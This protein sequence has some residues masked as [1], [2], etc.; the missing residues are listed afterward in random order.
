MELRMSA[1]NG[2][3]KPPD[4]APAE[5]GAET[6]TSVL[7]DAVRQLREVL[8]GDSR[9][10][11]NLSTAGGQ[12][13]LI[14]RRLA[15]ASEK[16]PSV[17]RE[18]GLSA[19]QVWQAVAENGGRDPRERE[20]VIVFTDLV[21]F[22]D[23]AMRVGDESALRLLRDVSDAIEPPVVA[24]RG[25]IVKR[26]GDGMM[27]VFADPRHAVDAVFEAN[28]R[29][30]MVECGGYRPQIR[31]GLHVGY[32]QRIGGDYLGIDVN[33]AA[34][35]AESAKGGEVLISEEGVSLLGDE[36]L[37][38][39]KKRFFKAKGVPSEVTVY[40]LRQR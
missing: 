26:L 36:D 17:L 21:N 2:F 27:A 7:L 13:G 25:E 40:S 35:I 24:R 1:E 6:K 18:A 15:E 9:F 29:L 19:L 22:S 30:G 31:A 16:R 28:E 5:T 33:V 3:D 32:P 37:S 14:A 11:D 10:G 34:R 8:P 4:E 38:A 20:L 12:A 39:R 23:W